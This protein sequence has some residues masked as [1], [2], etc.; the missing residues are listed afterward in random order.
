[1]ADWR[2]EVTAASDP[3]ATGQPVIPYVDTYAAACADADQL[4]IFDVLKGV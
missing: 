3:A 4:S 2:P 1:V